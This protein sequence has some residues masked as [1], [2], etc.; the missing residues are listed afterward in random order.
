MIGH[1]TQSSKA[2]H[3]PAVTES[4]AGGLGTLQ[5]DKTTLGSKGEGPSQGLWSSCIGSSGMVIY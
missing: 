2:E 4:M 1:S 3:K 5:R